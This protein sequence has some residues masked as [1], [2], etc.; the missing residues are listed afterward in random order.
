[1]DS[2]NWGQAQSRS[3]WTPNHLVSSSS[4]S[5]IK[6]RFSS[7]QSPTT[8]VVAY[9]AHSHSKDENPLLKFVVSGSVAW[10][11]ELVLGHYLEFLKIAKQTQEKTYVQLTRDMAKKGI[12]GVLDGF[13]PWG[14]V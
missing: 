3:I 2:S 9:S 11:Y 10:A 8:Q 4:H 6:R 5:M 12:H 14:T 7:I 13:F 1:M